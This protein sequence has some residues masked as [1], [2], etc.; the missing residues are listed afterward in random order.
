MSAYLE[1][2][3]REFAA[4]SEA[5]K[6]LAP[7]DLPKGVDVARAAAWTA[8]GRVMLNVDEFITRE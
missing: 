8:V 1:S 7:K 5:A 6:K 2:Q 3:A 4:D